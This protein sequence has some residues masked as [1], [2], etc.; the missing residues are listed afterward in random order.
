MAEALL[1]GMISS[2]L[3]RMYFIAVQVIF[4]VGR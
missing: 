3:Y 4:A 1:R 2:E